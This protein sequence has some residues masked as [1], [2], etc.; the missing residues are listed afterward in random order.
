[1]KLPV[2]AKFLRDMISAASAARY[3]AEACF[4]R[5]RS[6][7]SARPEPSSSERGC[8]RSR[9]AG[10]G[11]VDQP[12]GPL[13]D[14]GVGVVDD[15]AL[16]VRHAQPPGAAAPLGRSADARRAQ[17]PPDAR[18]AHDGPGLSEGVGTMPDMERDLDA[19]AGRIAERQHGLIT[20]PRA[21]R[22]GFSQH[23]IDRRI[24]QGRWIRVARDVYAVRGSPHTWHRD[25]LAACLA[26]PPSTVTSFVTSGALWGVCRPCVLPYVTVPMAA[27]AR[28]RIARVHRSDLDPLDVTRIGGIPTTRLGRT[29]V[30]LA[31]IW[32]PKALERAL[33]TALDGELVRPGPGRAAIERAPRGVRRPGAS[34][35]LD[36]LGCGP[37]PSARTARPRRG[38]SGGST[39]GTCRCPSASTGSTI[40][41][42][43]NW[44][45]ST[46]RG[47]SGTSRSSTT[48]APTTGRGGSSTTRTGGPESRPWAGRSSP[49]PASTSGRARSDLRNRLTAMLRRP[50]A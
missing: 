10:L 9:T 1:M 7:S 49:S 29:L 38:S 26:G 39:N 19:H 46:S 8:S 32:T 21:R 37:T 30:D 16:D 31:G 17:N 14:V 41:T 5:T 2:A 23:Q 35:L 25:A 6:R 47:R 36:A 34:A 20:G 43:P 11:V 48:A 40:W 13:H 24:A 12:G 18:S 33:D 42:A 44:L 4:S 45:D 28:S 22:I 27:S 3:S 15:P 50:A